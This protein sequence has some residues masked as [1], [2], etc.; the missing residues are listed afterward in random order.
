MRHHDRRP[1]QQGSH[2]GYHPAVNMAERE[3]AQRAIIARQMMRSNSV[4]AS[5]EEDSR[6][7]E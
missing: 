6:A 5:R 2:C 3:H 4:R 7:S 1:A